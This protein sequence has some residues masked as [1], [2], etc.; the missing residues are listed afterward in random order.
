MDD[1]PLPG[2]QELPPRQHLAARDK[3]PTVGER[4]PR[5]DG[6]AWT[7]TIG[8]AVARPETLSLADLQTLPQTE[9]TLDIHCV[10]R[11]SKQGVRFSGVLLSTLLDRARPDAAAP[12]VSFT[13][14]SERG[15]S[16]SLTLA[17]ARAL[18]VLVALTVDG[19]AL[20]EARGGPVRIV[21]PRRYFYKSVKWLESIELLT[22]DRLGYWES[23]AGYHNTGDVWREQRYAT[24]EN[25]QSEIDAIL[26]GRDLSDRDLR[27][28]QAAGRDL[29][30]LIARRALLRDA[31]FRGCQLRGACFDGA[32]LNNARFEGTDLRDASFRDADLEGADFSGADL[33]G[34]LFV[35]ASL[36]GAS[37]GP[38]NPADE[39]GRMTQ[40]DARTQVDPAAG[41]GGLL[42]AAQDG[43]EQLIECPDVTGDP[44]HHCGS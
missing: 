14:R 32:N 39:T 38:S 11:W 19:S 23:T 28:L 36:F 6:A 17:D 8:G 24:G 16:T 7:V 26:A 25:S 31:D 22:E 41:S 20:D 40:M 1:R 42:C 3:W 4:L 12:F 33:R 27:S 9:E 43:P 44:G 15:H 18:R 37:F 5:R 10:T 29:A 21:V 35:G 30:G 34:A 2:R 13:A